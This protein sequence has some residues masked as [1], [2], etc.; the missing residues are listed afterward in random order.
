MGWDLFFPLCLGIENGTSLQELKIPLG[1]AYIWAREGEGGGIGE[2]S[3]NDVC[4]C[5]VLIL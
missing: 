4:F 5:I 1:H 2:N 3:R